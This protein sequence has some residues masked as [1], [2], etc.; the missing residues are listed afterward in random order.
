MRSDTGHLTFDSKI[1]TDLV[2]ALGESPNQE[3]V[4]CR[5]PICG[6]SHKDLNK[7]RFAVNLRKCKYYCFNCLANGGTIEMAQLL[8]NIGHILSRQKT[9][10]SLQEKTPI[11]FELITV[12]VK[13]LPPSIKREVIADL[14][15][16]RVFTE[17]EIKELNYCVAGSK[18]TRWVGRV[19]IEADGIKFGKSIKKDV[20]PKYL[21]QPNFKLVKHG[22]INKKQITRDGKPAILAEGLLDLKSIPVDRGLMSPGTSGFF[23]DMLRTTATE[24]PLVVVPDSDKA[25]V[26]A[27]LRIVNK[28]MLEDPNAPLM[29]CFVSWLTGKIDDD[30]NDLR[31]TGLTKQEIYDILV[32][33]SLPGTITLNKLKESFNIIHTRHKGWIIAEDKKKSKEVSKDGQKR[34]TDSK[35]QKSKEYSRAKKGNNGGNDK[36]SWF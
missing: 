14:L 19:V 6:D 7:K 25:G 27:F 26:Q 17:E 16:R 10:D 9:P 8:M 30:I 22:Y 13:S 31:M 20:K 5:C 35:N 15:P 18:P 29:F 11:K 3:E 1:A 2:I 4:L 21:T 24:I 32:N 33:K 28:K 34:L 36:L 12:P 23:N